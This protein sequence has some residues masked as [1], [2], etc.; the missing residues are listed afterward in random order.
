[1]LVTNVRQDKLT[2]ARSV[3]TKKE[4]MQGTTLAYTTTLLRGDQPPPLPTI[5]E[6][7]RDDHG[8]VTGPQV[9]NSVKLAATYGESAHPT[10]TL[11]FLLMII[12]TIC[13]TEHNYPKLVSK[14]AI[15]I[16]Q[17]QLPTLIRQ[18]LFDQL[19]TNNDI[20]HMAV[21]LGDCPRFNGRMFIYHSTVARFYAPS[22]LC[23]S[24]GMYHKTIR[25]NPAWQGEYP[26][27]N[28]VFV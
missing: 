24:G 16:N 26:R 8:A 3:F 11:N 17:P 9:M 22:N 25:S 20:D 13:T 5:E 18:F 27:Y 15:H 28:T 7:G 4:T 6:E 1:M 10:N 14:I 23:G 2:A 19:N 21:P 12:C